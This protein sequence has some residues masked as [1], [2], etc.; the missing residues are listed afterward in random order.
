MCADNRWL[1]QQH[2]YKF[3]YKNR[4]DYLR[5]KYKLLLIALR[6]EC[7]LDFDRWLDLKYW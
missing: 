1:N 2:E 5:A 3:H 7:W 4:F 6:F